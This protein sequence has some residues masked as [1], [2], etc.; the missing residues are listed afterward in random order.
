[1]KM[2]Y[3]F[4]LLTLALLL[5][6]GLGNSTLAQKTIAPADARPSPLGLAQTTLENGTYL[7]VFYSSP[8]MKGRKIFGDLVPF[9]QVWRTGANEAT[10]ITFSKDATFGGK[11]VKAGTYALFTLPGADKWTVILNSG[12]G[13]WGAFSYN[14]ELDVLRVEA[15]P[16]N[17]VD[18]Y[19]A[20]TM[21]FE[22]AAGG[23]H[24]VMNWA[25]TRV[26]V[27]IMAK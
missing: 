19:E 17:S 12:L 25:N 18:A 22:E 3:R 1:M 5:F 24:L 23:A 10:E 13:Q 15:T 26:A 16:T 6:T 21:A 4:I 20:F 8:R 9:G 7:K 11:A 2:S 27:P 14:A